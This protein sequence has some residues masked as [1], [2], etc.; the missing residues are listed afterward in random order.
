M[1]ICESQNWESGNEMRGMGTGKKA[2]WGMGM[3]GIR[4]RM[5]RIAGN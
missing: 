3:S 5:C 4:V 2:I 1:A